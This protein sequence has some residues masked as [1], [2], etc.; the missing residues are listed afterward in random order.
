LNKA[1]GSVEYIFTH[2]ALGGLR[3]QEVFTLT[4]EPITRTTLCSFGKT[5]FSEDTRFCTPI[6]ETIS[7]Q[8]AE[9][10]WAQHIGRQTAD[11][12]ITSRWLHFTKT[13]ME[14]DSDRIWLLAIHRSGMTKKTISQVTSDLSHGRIIKNVNRTDLFWGVESF[15]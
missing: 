10:V 1:T 13:H 11:C 3:S 5:H 7:L 12:E 6:H 14:N 8:L 9:K 15:L 4:E 2:S